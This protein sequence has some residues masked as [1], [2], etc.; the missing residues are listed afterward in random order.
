MNEVIVFGPVVANNNGRIQNKLQGNIFNNRLFFSGT[1][2]RNY[3][4]GCFLFT[5]NNYV[6]SSII[7]ASHKTGLKKKVCCFFSVV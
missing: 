6:T 5:K 1:F 3:T 2:L 4:E 7:G